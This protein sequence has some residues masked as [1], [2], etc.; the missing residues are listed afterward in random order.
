MK[1][2][3]A[4]AVAQGAVIAALY[5][6]LTIMQNLLLPG[7]ASL[8][9]QF[10]IAEALTV[11]AVYT[12][13]AVP[14]L[15]VGCLIANLSSLS[16]LGAYDL[17]FG[18]AASFVAA[19]LMYLLRNVRWF[20]LPVLSALMPALANGVIVGLELEIFLIPGGFHLGSFLIQGG[21]V[22]LGEL[23]V[24]S[25]LGLPLAWLIENRRWDKKL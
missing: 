21:C 3:P 11:F 13:V 15:T 20:K 24:L 4:L 22:A 6:A 9:I 18:T 2:H 19:V 10:R 12:P 17:I 14:G 23:A 1:R 16:S 7:S 25:V 8:P 5:A